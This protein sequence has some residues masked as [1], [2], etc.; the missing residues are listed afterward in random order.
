MDPT[1][2]RQLA[3]TVQSDI[4]RQAAL[5]RQRRQ[6]RE[7]GGERPAQLVTP[8]RRLAMAVWRYIACRGSLRAPGA[9][10]APRCSRTNLVE[11]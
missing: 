6:A 8:T 5:D 1:F 10:V 3:M 9:V 7:E 2:A 4:L 11:D